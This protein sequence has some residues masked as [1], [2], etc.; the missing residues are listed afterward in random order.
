M[1]IKNTNDSINDVIIITKTCL[2]YLSQNIPDKIL[3]SQ[4]HLEEAFNSTRPSLSQQDIS[5]YKLT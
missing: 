3:I 2:L 5:K 1:P 4:N